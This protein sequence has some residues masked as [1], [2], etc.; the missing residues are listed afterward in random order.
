MRDRVQQPELG[1][2]QAEP[3]EC[4]LRC[5]R[6]SVHE[7]NQAGPDRLP[8][9]GLCRFPPEPLPDVPAIRQHPPAGRDDGVHCHSAP[10]HHRG[11]GGRGYCQG[12][13]AEL[14][15]QGSGHRLRGGGARA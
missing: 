6:H 14:A 13:G 4:C 7:E 12:E 5:I 9:A 3:P 1:Q 10:H 2:G 8:G 15:V 11:G